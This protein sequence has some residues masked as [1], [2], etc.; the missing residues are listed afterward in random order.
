MKLLL[1]SYY[2]P[3]QTSVG[4]FRLERFT[5]YFKNFGIDP[6]ILTVKNP[7]PQFHPYTGPSN[8]PAQEVYRPAATVEFPVYRIHEDR[9]VKRVWQWP[10]RLLKGIGKISGMA[11]LQDES[12]IAPRFWY[13]DMEWGWIRPARR[14]ALAL[15]KEYKPDAIMVSCPPFSSAKIGVWLKKKTGLPLILDFRDGWVASSPY[16]NHIAKRDASKEKHILSYTD[17]LIVTSDQDASTYR[18]ILGHD[19][20]SLVYNG[21]NTT[22]A[23][24]AKIKIKPQGTLVILYLGAWG[25]FGRSPATL[26]KVL[27]GVDFPWKLISIGSTN[28]MVAHYA[29]QFQVMPHVELVPNQ[30]R[31]ALPPWIAKADALFLIKGTPLDAQK[32]DTHIAAKTYDYLAT[33]LP[34]LGVL[35]TGDTKDMLQ[36]YAAQSYIAPPNAPEQLEI[37]IRKLHMDKTSGNL[38]R[39]PNEEFLKN[40]DAEILTR[41]LANVLKQQI[42]SCT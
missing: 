11:T 14:Q 31:A 17:Q 15:I 6:V 25:V 41:Q 26:L 37:N 2:F 33:G 18:K 27:S 12:T 38:M 5:Q 42:K 36:R 3:P 1:I 39:C 9:A 16:M 23:T 30:P 24:P 21:Y 4:V 19:K 10:T 35:P 32:P 7:C 28:Q 20:V 22:C 13:I 29:K 40:F 8:M 34:V